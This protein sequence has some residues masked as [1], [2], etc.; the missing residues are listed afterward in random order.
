MV[1]PLVQKYTYERINKY[2]EENP[3]EAKAIMNQ[4]LLAAK[5]REAAKKS[6]RFSKEKRLYECWD[7]ARKTSRLP[8][9]RPK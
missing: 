4:V 5:G 3:I 9:Q 2:L 8:K 6:K 7:T 1:R